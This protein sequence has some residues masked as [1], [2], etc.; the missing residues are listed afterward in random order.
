MTGSNTGDAGALPQLSPWEMIAY[1]ALYNA[2]EGGL[3]CPI[4]LDIEMLF[5]CSSGSTVPKYIRRLEEKGLIVVKR[6]QRFREV[7]IVATGKWTK[8]SEAM[9]IERPHV[10]RGAGSRTPAPTDRKPYKTRLR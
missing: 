3:P 9:H 6:Y 4:N 10:P 2:A 7:Q 1:D 8:R 5:G